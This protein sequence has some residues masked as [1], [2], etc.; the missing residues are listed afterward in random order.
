MSQELAEPSKQGAMRGGVEP[1]GRSPAAAGA[2]TRMSGSGSM[3]LSPTSAALVPLTS[4]AG[5]A[6]SSFMRVGSSASI[7]EGAA[8]GPEAAAAAAAAG[9]GQ[10]GSGLVAAAAATCS[11]PCNVVG[12]E[13]ASL[14]SAL[15]QGVADGCAAAGTGNVVSAAEP[16]SPTAQEEAEAQGLAPESGVGTLS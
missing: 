2:S 7:P 15:Q 6:G 4:P 9:V 12:M 5:T 10:E 8:A 1:S 13:S 3:L 14:H 16:V 11:C